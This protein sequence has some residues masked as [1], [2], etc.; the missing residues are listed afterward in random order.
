M[1]AIFCPLY[2]KKHL[3]FVGFIC[4]IGLANVKFDLLI[5]SVLSISLFLV[6]LVDM[7]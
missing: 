4:L 1:G 7:F 2:L 3:N 6:V 5:L